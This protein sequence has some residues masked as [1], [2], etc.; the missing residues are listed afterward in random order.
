MYMY[1]FVTKRE[2]GNN[3]FLVNPS[4]DIVWTT[5]AYI[6]YHRLKSAFGTRRF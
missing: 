5:L 2:W 6:F 4:K 3:L 1:T